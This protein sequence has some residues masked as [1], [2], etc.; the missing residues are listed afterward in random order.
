MALIVLKAV[1]CTEPSIGSTSVADFHI[2][3]EEIVTGK[4]FNHKKWPTFM[5]LMQCIK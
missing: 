3:L 2:P 1:V 5:D 4:P